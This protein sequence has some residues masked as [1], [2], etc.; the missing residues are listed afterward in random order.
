MFCLVLGEIPAQRNLF[1]VSI[2]NEITLSSQLRSAI[3]KIKK[4]TFTNVDENNLILWKVNI[5]INIEN[6]SKLDEVS[7]SSHEVNIGR[8]FR[9][10]ELFP[11][12]KIPED[13]RN[14]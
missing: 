12:D 1:A 14:Q 10:E 7:R 6:M 8:D 3:Y 2:T 5:P 13:Y 11:A 4:N 9:G